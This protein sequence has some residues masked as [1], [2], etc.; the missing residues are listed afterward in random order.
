M[1]RFTLSVSL[2]GILCA[3]AAAFAAPPQTATLAVE[4]MTCGTCPIVVKKA[5]E[6]IPGVSATGLPK[7]AV[8]RAWAALGGGAWSADRLLGQWSSMV[9]A[10]GQW[11][12]HGYGGFHPVAA[13]LTGL[14]V[15]PTRSRGRFD[16]IRGR[17]F[18]GG[19][20]RRSRRARPSPTSSPASSIPKPADV[21]R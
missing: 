3:G 18:G 20:Q 7:S 11:Q 10:E 9:V 21:T 16:D 5:L 2:I 14:T 1:I 19:R 6:R 17:W 12:P 4:N 8:Q 15:L 13:D